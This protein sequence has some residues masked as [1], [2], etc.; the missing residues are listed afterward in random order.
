MF[1]GIIKSIA[2]SDFFAFNLRNRDL[3]VAQQAKKVAPAQRVLDVG[4]G[5]A[6]YRSLFSHCVYRTQDFAALRPDQL[7]GGGYGQIDYVCDAKSIP[8]PD[9]S[10]DVILCTEVLEHHPEP[11]AVIHE[12][13]RILSAGGT[14]FLT[15]P[16]GSGIHQEPNHFYGG[17]TPYW[18]RR[19]LPEAGFG[20]ISV[21]P[22][23][24]SFRHYAQESIRFVR[25]TTPFRSS[26]SFLASLFWLPFWLLLVPVLMGLI[27]FAAKCLDRFDNEKRFTIGYHVR[28]VRRTE[29]ER[30]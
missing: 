13:A 30:T 3:W 18:Y 25:M 12:F 1:H 17:Y 19:F 27:P 29:R 9:E 20:D 26:L 6:P 7:R 28:A 10:F 23:A 15:A 2:H 22:N 5:S 11:V 4:A 16:L 24:G 21:E 14:L 8:V